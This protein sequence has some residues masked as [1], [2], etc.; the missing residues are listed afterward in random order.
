MPKAERHK[1]SRKDRD[2]EITIPTTSIGTKKCKRSEVMPAGRFQEPT[3]APRP[4]RSH[5]PTRAHQP[6]GAHQPTRARQPTGA[7]Q[8]TRAPQPTRPHR[9]TRSN[10]PTPLKPPS[11][12]IKRSQVQPSNSPPRIPKK[13]RFQHQTNLLK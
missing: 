1:R 3:G 8:P 2:P 10:Q 5:Q 12:S 11:D 7:H 9:P 13:T 6:T 4:T